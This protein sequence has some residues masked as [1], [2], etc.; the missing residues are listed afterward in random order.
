MHIKVNTCYSNPPVLL[1]LLQQESYTYS[2]HFNNILF[3]KEDLFMSTSPLHFQMLHGADYNPDQWLDRSDILEK[4]ILLMKE[5]HVNC[6]SLGIFAWVALEPEEGVYT[7][8]WLKDVID[9]L[10]QNNIYTI[11]ATPSGARPA[12]MAQK[13][14]EVLRVEKDLTRNRMG[15]RHNHCYTSP[16]Y[17]KKTWEMNSRLAKEFGNHPGVILWHLSNEYSGE[18]YCP[19]CQDAFRDWLKEKYTT[20]D[21]LNHAWWTSFWS[22]TYT[23]WSQIEPPMPKGEMSTQGLSLDWMRFVTHQT[24]D[25]CK[26]EKEAVRSAGSSLPVTANLMGF[27]RGVNYFKLKDVLDVVSWDSYPDWNTTEDDTD[28]AISIGITHDLMRSIKRESF[29]LMESTPSMVNWKPIAHLKRPGM[30][31]LSSLQALAHGSNSVQY[32]QWRKS[33]GSCEKFHGAV[34]DHYGESDTRVFQDVAE[35]GKRLEGL[36]EVCKTSVKP[37]VAILFDWENRWAIENAWGPRNGCIH[38]CE[39][40]TSHYKA[41]WELGIPVDL[42]D[43]ECD[44][45]EYK[46]VIAPLLYLYRDNIENKMKQF[47]EQGGTLVGTYWSGVVDENDLCILGGTPGNMT[48][49]FGLR[50]EEVDA[51]HDDQ[52]NSITWNGTDYKVTELCDLVKINDA[53]VLSVYN[54]DFYANSPALTSHS[55]GSGKAYYIAARMEDAFYKDF[56]KEL[57]QE[58]GICSALDANLPHGV[59]ANLRKGERDI[60]I[61]Q[62]YNTFSVDIDIKNALIDI[63]T[64]KIFKDTLHLEPYQ[65]IFAVQVL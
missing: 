1:L 12:W 26:M 61:I 27:Y 42:I 59:T 55:Y 36:S 47:T 23:D 2:K 14:P 44:I 18:C 32:F 49:V 25:F 52:S 10:Y 37:E 9:T 16:I 28:V 54:K 11:L 62:N 58:I 46:L 60:I 8:D 29:L 51:L 39:T 35:L 22:H 19:L 43:M 30:H 64:N 31:M 4:D 7:F 40:V 17:R 45:S 56:Y 24:V 13:Y 50:S 38:Y 20:L 34:V 65:V 3:A 48:D 6:V 41:F 53:N 15:E 5:A 33:R 57:M 21:N 63:E